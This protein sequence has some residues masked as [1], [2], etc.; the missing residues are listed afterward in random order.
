M[1]VL[2]APPQ[3]RSPRASNSFCAGEHKAESKF[4][5]FPFGFSIRL[6]LA[7]QTERSGKVVSSDSDVT[8]TR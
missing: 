5:P 4:F 3:K 2:R 6:N 1:T 7:L 8:T